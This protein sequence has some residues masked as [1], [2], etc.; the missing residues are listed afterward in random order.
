LTAGVVDYNFRAMDTRSDLSDPQTLAVH[1]TDVATT[2]REAPVSAFARGNGVVYCTYSAYTRG[3]TDA[4]RDFDLRP[5]DAVANVA[6]F[7]LFDAVVFERTSKKGGIT[8]AALSQVAADLLAIPGRGPNEAEA[9]V[10]W[11]SQNEDA[12]RA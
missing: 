4:E 10:T 1:G 12:W 2:T 9:L 11:M 8:I 3:P 6:L 7:I 5:T